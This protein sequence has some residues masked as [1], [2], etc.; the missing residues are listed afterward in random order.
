MGSTAR[1][2]S[3]TEQ[4]MNLIPYIGGKYALIKNIVPI[5]EYCAEAYGLTHYFEMC[6]GGAKMLLNLF[7]TIFEQ[8]SYNDMDLGLCKLFACLG[9]KNY[10]YDL[11]AKLEDLGISEEIFLN[12]LQA[13]EFETRMLKKGHTKS[14]LDYVTA[15]AYTYILATLSRAADMSRYDQTRVLDS[16]RRNSYFKR[17][18]QLDRFYP[19][20]KDVEV[21]HGDCRELLDLHSYRNDAFA[22]LDPPYT[23]DEMV[24]QEHYGERSW[25][26]ADHESLVD[27]LLDT[28]MKVALSGY[29]NVAY[30]RLVAAGWR[31]IYLK[32]IHVSSSANGRR[33]DEFLWINFDIP[34]SLEDQVSQYDYSEC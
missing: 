28:N 33:S 34:S 27:R 16:A 24:L 22:Y 15:A 23:P 20:L 8:R 1:K 14:E 21:T 18:S 4:T 13:R 10:L 17:I 29:D 31:Q 9:D 12:A 2:T 7:P 11:V 19:I 25:T 5:I 32:N 26:Y 3:R 6:G 30:A